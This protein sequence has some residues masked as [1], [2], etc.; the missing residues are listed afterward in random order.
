MI[1]AR[2]LFSLY[3]HHNYRLRNLILSIVSRYDG[4]QHYSTLLR[5]IFKTYHEVTIGLYTHGACFSID[6]FDPQTTVG[7]YCSL[8]YGCRVLNVNHPMDFKSTH[9]FF[10]NPILKFVDT[11]LA[12]YIPLTIGNDVWIGYNAIIMPNVRTISNGAVI[13]AG[14]VVNKDVPPYAVVVGNPGRV[15]RFR[16][17]PQTIAELESS[18]WWEKSIQ[19]LAQCKEEFCRI[20]EADGVA[21]GAKQADQT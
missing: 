1:A 6:Q 17:S 13:A 4:G 8:A 2:F 7:R 19:E 9:A 14:A 5:N 21:A 3:R 16:F 15:V 11:N 12:E 20:Y 18:R 10:F